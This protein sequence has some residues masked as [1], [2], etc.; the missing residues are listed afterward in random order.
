[1]IPDQNKFLTD[2]AK[3]IEFVQ[4]SK[5]WQITSGEFFRT[6]V[7][8]WINALPSGSRLMAQ[9]PNDVVIQYDKNVGGVGV[10]KS[11]HC[12]R[13]AADFNFIFNGELINN[14]EQIRVFGNFWESL[15]THNKWGGNFSKRD[16]PYHFERIV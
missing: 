13:L 12:D 15:D 3:L 14:K 7:Q 5:L 11:I 10:R 6:D 16:D 1:M 4:S 8:A 9:F 2:I